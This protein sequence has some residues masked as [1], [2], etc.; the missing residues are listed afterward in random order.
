M[1]HVSGRFAARNGN[2]D[3]PSLSSALSYQSALAHQLAVDRKNAENGRGF[4][5]TTSTIGT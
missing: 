1:R 5:G 3:A 2:D 4:T